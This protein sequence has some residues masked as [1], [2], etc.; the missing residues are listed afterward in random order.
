MNAFV[1]AL[2]VFGAFGH[3]RRPMLQTR[4]VSITLVQMHPFHYCPLTT[5]SGVN[6]FRLL[7][8][9]ALGHVLVYMA[10]SILSTVDRHVSGRHIS[11][12]C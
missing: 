6:A 7:Y 9:Q 8:L 5:C 11:D 4:L 1:G 10:E 3:M 12:A 2:M